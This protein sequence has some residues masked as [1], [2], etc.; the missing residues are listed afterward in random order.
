MLYNGSHGT[1]VAGIIRRYSGNKAKLTCATIGLSVTPRISIL[2]NQAALTEIARNSPD[3]GAFV[4]AVI[5]RHR[6]DSVAKGRRASDYLRACGAGVANMSWGRPKSW[7]IQL[8][9]G[10]R[11]VYEKEG[12]DPSSVDRDYSGVTGE[13][14]AEFPLELTIADAAAFALAFYENPDVFVTISAGNDHA[15]NDA[16]LPSPQYLSRF[17]PNV[18]T[19]ASTDEEGKPSSFTNYGV[20]SVQLAAPGE[21]IQSSILVGM[22]APMSGTSMASPLV[23]GVAAGIRADFPKISAADV[24]RILEYSATRDPRLAEVVSTSGWI[25]AEAARQLASKWSGPTGSMLL[26]E[27]ARDRHPGQDG[28]KITALQA[29]TSLKSKGAS[30]SKGWRITTTGGF[31]GSWRIVMSNGSSYTE[32]CQFGVGEWPTKEIDEAWNKDFRVTS[33]TGDAGGWNV[34]MSKG[35]PGGQR[36]LGMDLDQ[37]QLSNLMKEGWRITTVGGWNKQWVFALGNQTGYGDQR[38]TLPTPLDERRREWI[39]K[40][41]DEGYRITSLA[42]DDTPQSDDDGWLFV[43]SMDSGLTDQ[44]YEGPGSWPAEWIA[45]RQKEGY[46][47]TAVAGAEGRSMVVMSKGSDLREQ[48]ISEGSDYPVQWIKERW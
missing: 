3:Y 30:A 16:G 42:G 32:Q 41:W 11:K 24:R 15:D 17:F 7:F 21:N 20:R 10:I 1:H 44:T 37:N 4:N 48:T 47:V 14:I 39:K 28:P 40:R 46:R 34:V 8:A 2:T 45:A 36:L 12:A 25:N 33:I 5:D 13:R 19:I 27:V 9:E 29:A 6:S 18:I 22:E 31:N 23:A 38:Y 26:A 35:V 43:M